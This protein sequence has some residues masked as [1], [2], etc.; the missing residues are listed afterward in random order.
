LGIGSILRQ[1]AERLIFEISIEVYI[2]LNALKLFFRSEG[3]S[4]MLSRQQTQMT[5]HGYIHI[6]ITT[7]EWDMDK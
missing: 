4:N 1:A 2:G 3:D 7:H 6:S 5:N